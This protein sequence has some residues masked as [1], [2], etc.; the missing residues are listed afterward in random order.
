MI[1]FGSYLVPKELIIRAGSVVES[2]GS[3]EI[4][5]RIRL[6]IGVGMGKYRCCLCHG[7]SIDQFLDGDLFGGLC[8][9]LGASECSLVILHYVLETACEDLL[10]TVPL[11]AGC[12][13]LCF[14]AEHCKCHLWWIVAPVH[15]LR[16]PDV[17]PWSCIVLGCV[18]FAIAFACATF[19]ALALALAF[20]AFSS[21]ISLRGRGLAF[22]IRSRVSLSLE[23]TVF[24]VTLS[25]E[26]PLSRR[27]I[28]FLQLVV[29]GVLGWG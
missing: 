22:P 1:V 25:R 23:A 15:L 16:I 27:R 19:A 6:L 12:L 17:A 3:W 10:A 29:S 20:A 13:I 2:L 18:P 28:F 24:L 5:Y 4:P 21:S 14:W 9:G 11:W 8:L 26:I 7:V